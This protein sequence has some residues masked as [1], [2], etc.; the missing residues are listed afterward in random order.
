MIKRI[1]RVKSDDLVNLKGAY[2]ISGQL[3][4]ISDCD[5]HGTICISSS[6]GPILVT[7]DACPLL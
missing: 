1:N 6:C 2:A 4:D 3:L 5:C 7:F